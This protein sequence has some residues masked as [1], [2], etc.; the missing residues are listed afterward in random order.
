ML[1]DTPGIERER[2]CPVPV[3]GLCVRAIGL[4]L[5][6]SHGTL[7]RVDL[8]DLDV[9]SMAVLR[10]L[11]LDIPI[12]GGRRPDF[13]HEWKRL[14]IGFEV[15]VHGQSELRDHGDFG[16]EVGAFADMQCGRVDCTS[17]SSS[18]S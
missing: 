11:G 7:P 13:D 2:D 15:P 5:P 17:K 18:L 1:I 8:P 10:D 16:N 6:H 9:A 3:L 4:A 12:P 14:S